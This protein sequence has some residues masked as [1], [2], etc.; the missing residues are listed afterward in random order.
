MPLLSAAVLDVLELQCKLESKADKHCATTDIAN[1]FFSIP[2]AAACNSLLSRERGVQFTWNRWPQ[3][4]KHSHTICHGL[5]QAALDQGD[6]PVH[7]PYIND[8]IKWGNKAVLGGQKGLGV[9]VWD[10]VS[11]EWSSRV[12]RDW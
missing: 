1:V 5:I 12:S 3:G 11:T 10:L 9:G 7:L 2:L 6:P 8:T 4:W